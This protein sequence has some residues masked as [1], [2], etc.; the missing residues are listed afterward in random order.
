[1]RNSLAIVLGAT[2]ASGVAM[3]ESDATFSELDADGNGQLNA[4]EAT[5]AGIDLSAVD[6]DGDGA[7]SKEEYQAAMKAMQEEG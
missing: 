3:A 5:E 4:A 6:A 2:L 7:V 1:M